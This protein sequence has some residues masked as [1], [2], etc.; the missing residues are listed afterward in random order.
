MIMPTKQQAEIIT[1]ITS[2]MEKSGG[3]DGWFVGVTDKPKEQLF[4]VC[5][6]DKENAW[7]IYRTAEDSPTATKVKVALLN[8]GF[9]LDSFEKDG[10]TEA[11]IIYAYRKS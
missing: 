3:I 8:N 11:K 6:V 7:W 1:D 9:K 10:I 5:N 2:H 4:E